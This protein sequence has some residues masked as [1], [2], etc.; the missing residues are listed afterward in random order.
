MIKYFGPT[1][2]Q[3][4]ACSIPIGSATFVKIEIFSVVILSLQLSQERQLSVFC[5]KGMCTSNG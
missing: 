4:V 3:E 2:D 1:G 5:G